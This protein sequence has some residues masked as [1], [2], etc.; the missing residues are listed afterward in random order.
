[1]DELEG[2]REG[3]VMQVGGKAGG[4]RGMNRLVVIGP[5]EEEER[6]TF[7]IAPRFWYTVIFLIYIP[8]LFY[9]TYTKKI[10]KVYFSILVGF[11]K[12]SF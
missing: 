5:K 4:R 10:P 7:S 9:R 12:S 3:A 6:E 2:L 1:M 8:N 11:K